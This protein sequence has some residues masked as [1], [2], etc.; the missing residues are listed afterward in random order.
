MQCEYNGQQYDSVYEICRKLDIPYSSLRRHMDEYDGN[1]DKA[2]AVYFDSQIV[3]NVFGNEFTSLIGIAQFYCL[4]PNILNTFIRDGVPVEEAVK[5]AF[6]KRI[7]IDGEVYETLA[8]VSYAYKISYNILS[9]RLSKGLS[10]VEAVRKPAVRKTGRSVQFRGITYSSY[11]NLLEELNITR[12]FVNNVKTKENIDFLEALELI[13]SFYERLEI[14][15][16][17]VVS[18]IPYAVYNGKEV[19]TKIDLERLCGIPVHT[20]TQYMRDYNSKDTFLLMDKIATETVKRY[21]HEGKNYTNAE[22]KRHKTVKFSDC[23]EVQ[24]RKFPNATYNKSGRNIDTKEEWQ[25]HVKECKLKVQSNN[26]PNNNTKLN[27]M[28]I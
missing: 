2:V 11:V 18:C 6:N 13:V 8:D 26:Q 25:K 9:R 22:I 7:F 17:R 28:A 12:F 3:Y 16:D 10:I 4:S 27:D 21:R 14:V 5:K 15:P 24:V 23:K 1:I 19:K 20:I